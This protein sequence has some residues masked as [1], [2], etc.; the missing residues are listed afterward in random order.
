MT[1]ADYEKLVRPFREHPERVAALK[2]V[3][4]AIVALCYAAFPALLVWLLVN[5]SYARLIRDTLIPGSGFLLL[6]FV[7]AKI[8]APRPYER[9]IDSLVS[10]RTQGKSF[11]SR[12]VF[13][14]FMIAM[15]FLKELPIIGILFLVLGCLLAVTRVLHGVHYPKDVIAGALCG[16]L[17]GVI[18]LFLIF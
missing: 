17:W 16:I 18:F 1:P 9:G 10:K 12:H 14:V 8:N 15:T 13:S 5:G 4:T 11:P 7:R 3:N 2:F 6:S